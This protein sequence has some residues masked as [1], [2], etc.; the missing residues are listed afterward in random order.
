MITN[1]YLKIFKV[2]HKNLEPEFVVANSI[3]EAIE[4]FNT[5]YKDNYDITPEGIE[6]VT[7]HEELEVLDDNVKY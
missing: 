7:L 6:S 1:N 3:Q 2:K 4:K 5:Y